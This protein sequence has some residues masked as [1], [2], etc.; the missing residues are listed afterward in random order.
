MINDHGEGGGT[1]GPS[2]WRQSPGNSTAGRG[3]GLCRRLTSSSE[4]AQ[5]VGT[6]G[7]AV[8]RKAGG[9]PGVGQ[10][11]VAGVTGVQQAGATEG[12]DTEEGEES[13]IVC[14]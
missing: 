14:Q 13:V 9:G 3:A 1:A 2:A 7:A 11:G 4:V 10:P 8:D 12:G 5:V 6:P